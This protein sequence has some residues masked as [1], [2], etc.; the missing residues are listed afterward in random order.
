MFGS[1]VSGLFQRSVSS[2]VVHVRFDLRLFCYE[3]GLVVWVEDD[4]IREADA[5]HGEQVGAFL[6]EPFFVCVR[7]FRLR[8]VQAELC[9]LADTMRHLVALLRELPE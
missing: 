9:R 1:P 5:N 4:S 2:R 6:R 3:C 7:L 8:L